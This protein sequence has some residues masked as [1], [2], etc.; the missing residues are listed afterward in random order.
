MSEEHNKDVSNNIIEED[1]PLAELARIVAGEISSPEEIE[2]TAPIEAKAEP[3]LSAQ[4]DDIPNFD[5]ML[6]VEIEPEEVPSLEQSSVDEFQTE[7]ISADTADTSTIIDS[8]E[9]PSE[10]EEFDSLEDDL[11]AVL[12]VP[13]S[14]N[15]PDIELDTTSVTAPVMDVSEPAQSDASS[16]IPETTSGFDSLNEPQAHLEEE[17][18]AN[19]SNIELEITQP[20]EDTSIATGFDPLPEDDSPVESTNKLVDDQ[21]E[22][23]VTETSSTTSMQLDELIEETVMADLSQSTFEDELNNH[24]ESELIDEISGELE[25]EE[26]TY[27]EQFSSTE[28][29]NSV[30]GDLDIQHEPEPLLED[31]NAEIVSSQLEDVESFSTPQ[32]TDVAANLEQEMSAAFDNAVERTQN[33]SDAISNQSGE[34]DSISDEV[35]QSVEIDF[36]TAFAEELSIKEQEA[37][38]W[39]NND[40][41]TATSDFEEAAIPSSADDVQEETGFSLTEGGIYAG[42]ASAGVAAT[43]VAKAETDHSTEPQNGPSSYVETGEDVADPG[44][45]HEIADDLYEGPAAANENER[46]G[47]GMKYAVAA[48]VISLFAGVIVTGYG[49]LG[50]SDPS[51]TAGG[52]GEVAIIKADAAPFKVKPENPGGRVVSNTDNVTFE[53]VEGN[54]VAKVSQEKLVSRTEEPANIDTSA[55]PTQPIVD[56]SLTPK[57]TERITTSDTAE[58]TEENSGSGSTVVAP[59]VVQTLT[60]KP[61]GT[62]LKTP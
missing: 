32:S 54:D 22:L 42:A 5:D 18:V 40:T 7:T 17:L 39:D 6:S 12:D 57:S 4:D 9:A 26:E 13:D 35:E 41:Q 2:D 62:I 1:D 16:D 52:S 36:E 49:F 50:K 38:G 31:N 27:E 60:V 29:L 34:F 24:L 30:D 58:G 8:Y 28:N 44:H 45:M 43:A 47:G 10:V 37:A 56:T 20:V 46:S 48:L 3:D 53:K 11:V 19:L 21:A 23:P 55:V 15:N 25:I 61:D 51:L 59:R 14:D 33:F